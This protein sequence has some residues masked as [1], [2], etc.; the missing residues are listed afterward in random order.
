MSDGM[1]LQLLLAAEWE[2]L[3]LEMS[4]VCKLDLYKYG[5]LWPIDGH[6]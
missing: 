3:W 6:D 1:F 5:S 2:S 4:F